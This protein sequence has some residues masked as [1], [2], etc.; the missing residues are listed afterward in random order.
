MNALGAKRRRAPV[1]YSATSVNVMLLFTLTGGL[2]KNSRRGNRA[3]DGRC[4]TMLFSTV[5]STF[6]DRIVSTHD[7]IRRDARMPQ[8]ASDILSRY[9]EATPKV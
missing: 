3:I 2:L 8:R 4:S 1:S 9:H 5:A 6:K 7:A